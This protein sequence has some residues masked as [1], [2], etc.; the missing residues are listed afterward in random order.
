MRLLNFLLMFLIC[1]GFVLFSLQNTELTTIQVIDGIEL[2]AP[3]AVELIVATG[4]GAVLAW[5][6]SL[7]SRM[8]QMLL[9]RDKA[10]LIRQQEQRIHEL[11]Q[12]WE[13]YQAE[14]SPKLL[15]QAE[16]VFEPTEKT[17]VQEAGGHPQTP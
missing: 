14:N 11:E 15:S 8:Q 3:L 5:V 12:G 1:L 2:E 7:W 6:F 16:A 13:P 4:V 10:R 9:S 17:D